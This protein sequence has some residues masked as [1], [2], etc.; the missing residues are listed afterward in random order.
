LFVVEGAALLCSCD[1]ELPL[2]AL[3]VLELPVLAL[4]LLPLLALPVLALPVLALLALPDFKAV[5]AG[6]AVFTV[7]AA[8]GWGSVT[9]MATAPRTL[10]APTPRVTADIR[11]IPLVRARCRAEPEVGE[12]VMACSDPGLGCARYF[13]AGGP[14]AHHGVLACAIFG[15]F[16]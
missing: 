12:P 13:A 7:P 10:A 14:C 15:C 9:A 5:V 2:L 3:P 6:L 8:L 11:A 4:P 1:V 16:L